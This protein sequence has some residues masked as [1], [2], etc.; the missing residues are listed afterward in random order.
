MG[1][2]YLKTKEG[3]ERDQAGRTRYYRDG[4]TYQMSDHLPLWIELKIDFSQEY[5]AKKVAQELGPDANVRSGGP[6]GGSLAPESAW[7]RQ[8]PACAS[9]S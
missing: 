4:R 9:P 5:L 6:G 1:P 2:A 7:E 3:I 8:A